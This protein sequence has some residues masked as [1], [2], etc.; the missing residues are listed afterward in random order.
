MEYIGVDLGGSHV[1]VLVINSE[2]I[3]LRRITSSLENRDVSSVIDTIVNCCITV[4]I[5]TSKCQ[6]LGIAV[7]GNV[8]PIKGTTRYLPNFGWLSEVPIKN[9]LTDKL[10]IMNIHMRNDG[11]CAAIAESVLGAG[12]N[13][14]VFAMLTLGTGIGGALIINGRLIDGCSFDAGDFGHHVI[15]TREPMA[16]VCGKVGCFETHASAQGLVRHFNRLGGNATNAEDILKLYRAADSIAINAFDEFMEDLS[17][18]L[19]N[20]VTFYNPDVIAIGGGLSRAP[21]IY[22]GLQL[23]VDK[24]TLPASRGKVSILGASLGN[25]AGAI[26]AALLLQTTHR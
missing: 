11:R 15:A 21:E 5:D 4:G 14:Q 12:K 2:G 25:D 8:D 17:T 18:G 1:C 7:P 3:I 13:S 24:K 10:G 16:C 6:G 22:K 19:A 20:L 26:G 23:A 9:L